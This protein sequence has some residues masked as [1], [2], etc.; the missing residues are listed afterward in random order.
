MGFL[1]KIGDSIKSGFKSITGGEGIGGLIKKG[2]G[3]LVEKFAP[4]IGELLTKSPLANIVNKVIDFAGK[5][6]PKMAESGGLLGML[7]GVLQKVG[8]MGSLADIAQNLLKKIGGP[9]VLSKFGLQNLTDIFA[10][11]QAQIMGA[12]L[13]A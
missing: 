9:D 5:V 12:A 2:V 13:G 8:G 1:K 11:R 10:Q 3:S 7:G 4:K 6:G